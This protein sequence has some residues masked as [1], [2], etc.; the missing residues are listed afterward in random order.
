MQLC[1]EPFFF[2]YTTMT[3]NLTLPPYLR[4]W[5]VHSMGGMEPV[6]FPKGSAYNSFLRVFLR[7]KREM[8][9]WEPSGVDSVEITVPRFPG[10]DPA[11]YNYL[12]SRARDALVSLVRDAFDVELYTEMSAFHNAIQSRRGAEI[13]NVWMEEHGIELTDKNTCAVLKRLQ[14]LKK[15]AKD[16]ER[17]REMYN[18]NKK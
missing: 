17:K 11:Y 8:E 6:T 18:A 15:R 1:T 12:P 5:L 14:L 4:E 13:L 7:H 16:R 10:K 3:F 9:T 2:L